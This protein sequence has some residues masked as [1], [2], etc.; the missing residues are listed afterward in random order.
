MGIKYMQ[1]YSKSLDNYV[2]NDDFAEFF[3]MFFAQCNLGPFELDTTQS[4]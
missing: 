2:Y 1:S 3:H 4:K